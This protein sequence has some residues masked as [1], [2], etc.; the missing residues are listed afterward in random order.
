MNARR[1]TAS[2][3]WVIS[4]VLV[5]LAWTMLVVTGQITEV[6]AG[7]AV[8][9]TLVALAVP[10]LSAAVLHRHPQEWTGPLLGIAVLAAVLG[11]CRDVPLGALTEIAGMIALVTV[12]LP[13]LIAVR[14]PALQSPR[15]AVRLLTG[16]GWVCAT[17]GLAVGILGLAGSSV[18]S[19]WWW[20][21]DPGPASVASTAL[22][23]GYVLVVVLAAAGAVMTAVSRYRS[24]PLG[25]RASIRPLVLPLAGWAVAVCMSSGWILITG[26]ISPT[27]NIQNDPSTSFY[28]LMPPL[29]VGVLAA[30]I[31]W[32][33]LMVRKPSASGQNRGAARLRSRETFVE[34]Y[35]SRA[36]ADPS[37]Q[38]LYPSQPAPGTWVEDWLDSQGQV[39]RP[40]V[41]D[42]DRAVTLIRRGSNLIGLIDLDA[43]VTARP[44]AVELVASGAG[45]Y[46]ETEGLLAAA[47]RDLEISRQL[48]TRLLTATD[49]PRAELRAQLLAGPLRELDSAAM[50]L[51]AGQPLARVAPRLNSISAQL[52][53]IS[54]GLFPAALSS[55]GLRAALPGTQVPDHRYSPVV[56]MTVYLAAQSAESVISDARLDG[57]PVVQILTNLAPTDTVRDRVTA[58]GGLVASVEGHWSITVPS[59]S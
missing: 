26:V 47:R 31:G 34:Q 30:G 53:T 6:P 54:H 39:V 35:L 57:E 23:T 49:E 29:M 17:L 46:M 40:D 15:L 2:A 1:I 58:L 43:A 8:F 41:L 7:Q 50:D 52:R 36:L 11:A 45:L 56:E 19:T 25:G 48:A 9:L 32:I 14:H 13:A 3:L 42:P 22:L 44:D 55:S 12:L 21:S 18:P 16:C 59:G 20:T 10:A 24:M 37:I 27:S 4:G 51:G 5:V 38:V 28:G 33:D